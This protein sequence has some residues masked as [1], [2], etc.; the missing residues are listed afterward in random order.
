[1][2]KAKFTDLKTRSGAPAA[3]TLTSEVISSNP[4]QAYM[5]VRI[6]STIILL[7]SFFMQ[8]GTP[9]LS[10]EFITPFSRY[11]CVYVTAETVAVQ[12]PFNIRSV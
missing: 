3:D 10:F 6:I 4:G 1:M 8:V 12:A 5:Q 2:N 9:T 7:I 11:C